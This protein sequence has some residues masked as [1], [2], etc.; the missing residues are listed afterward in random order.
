MTVWF[1]VTH[2]AVYTAHRFYV[3]HCVPFFTAKSEVT[4][5]NYWA[6]KSVAADQKERADL[7]EKGLVEPSLDN[8]GDQQRVR[9][10]STSYEYKP[11]RRVQTG[12]PGGMGGTR[13]REAG[14]S[15]HCRDIV[16]SE[17]RSLRCSGVEEAKSPGTQQSLPHWGA[18]EMHH[19]PLNT[20][21]LVSGSWKISLSVER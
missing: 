20:C 15:R 9:E 11:G 14:R 7:S 17:Q 13:S 18:Q 1:T 10:H 5:S 21:S 2:H 19:A 3:L 4:L 16:S 12:W 6:W 8:T